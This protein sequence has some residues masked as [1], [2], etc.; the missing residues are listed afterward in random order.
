M[1]KT[2]RSAQ[3]S[4]NIHKKCK[5]DTFLMA[6][7]R[8]HSCGDIVEIRASHYHC[9]YVGNRQQVLIST[10]PGL[11]RVNVSRLLLIKQRFMGK[12]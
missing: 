6:G 5:F 12:I 4:G 3:V 2:I 10:G 7:I 1:G 11:P 9:L 8:C